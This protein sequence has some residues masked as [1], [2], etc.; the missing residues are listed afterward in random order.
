MGASNPGRSTRGRP[1]HALNLGAIFATTYL[2]E[3]Q[4]AFLG[5]AT[6]LSEDRQPGYARLQW[7]PW[8]SIFDRLRWRTNDS[9]RAIDIAARLEEE[10]CLASKGGMGEYLEVYPTYVG[11]VR[12]SRSRR[13]FRTLWLV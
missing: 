9:A 4:L 3:E 8:R 11:S 5:A 6:A 12:Q 7:V 10:G 13:S 1:V 2:D